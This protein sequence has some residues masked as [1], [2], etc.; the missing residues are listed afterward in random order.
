TGSILNVYKKYLRDGI[1]LASNRD[2]LREE[3]GDLLWYTAAVATAC[4][5]DLDDIAVN[6]LRRTRDRYLR[7]H[8]LEEL[9]HLPSLD[10]RYPESERFPRRL[11]VAFAE[12]RQPSGRGTS[13]LTLMSAE[14]NSFPNGPTMGVN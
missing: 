11:V 4:D 7:V 2:F 8:G 12:R 9:Q 13:A 1:D 6:N 10:V 5:L 3:L 14:P